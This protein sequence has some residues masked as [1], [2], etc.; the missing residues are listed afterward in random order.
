MMIYG[1]EKHAHHN[2]LFIGA[3]NLPLWL[4]RSHFPINVIKQEQTNQKLVFGCGSACLAFSLIQ[5][6]TSSPSCDPSGPLD[7][8]ETLSPQGFTSLRLCL[9]TCSS[10]FRH[11]LPC[12]V[13]GRLFGD[14]ESCDDSQVQRGND[15]HAILP[16]PSCDSEQERKNTNKF[17]TR[18]FLRDKISQYIGYFCHF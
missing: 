7:G 12:A 9:Q 3:F 13:C 15:K 2:K 17:Y 16:P 5:P 14:L 1:K 10:T 18:H 6:C 8:T 11:V 4:L